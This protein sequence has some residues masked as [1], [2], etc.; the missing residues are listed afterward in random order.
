MTDKLELTIGSFIEW[1]KM[2]DQN[3]GRKYAE[4]MVRDAVPQVTEALINGVLI[5][6]PVIE[7]AKE[8]VDTNF[9]TTG[10]DGQEEEATS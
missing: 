2:A 3:R 6:Q 9:K 7:N 4:D 8:P 5:E 10:N 1:V